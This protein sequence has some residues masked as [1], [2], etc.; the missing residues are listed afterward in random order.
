MATICLP[1]F[2]L[3]SSFTTPFQYH[4]ITSESVNLKCSRLNIMH[5]VRKNQKL[6]LHLGIWDEHTSSTG[7]WGH[8]SD[9]RGRYRSNCIPEGSCITCTLH[10]KRLG[11]SDQGEFHVAF[12]RNKKSSYKIM[13][14]N[15]TDIGRK[16]VDRIP[17][18]SG[19][20]ILSGTITPLG[21]I[22]GGK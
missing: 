14:Q 7:W 16:D 2:T 3:H 10:Q 1:L 13:V 4:L 21:S 22:Q 9:P 6:M 20:E 18:G 15:L 11:T 8:Y 19:Q 5:V 17:S 12:M